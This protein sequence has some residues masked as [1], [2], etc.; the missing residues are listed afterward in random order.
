MKRFLKAAVAA[1]V[2][3]WGSASALAANLSF[4]GNLGG[5]NDVQLFSFSLTSTA[6]VTLRT[7]SYAGGSN[8]AGAAIGA[9]GFDA[10]VAL[11]SGTGGAALLIN[12][13]D[14]G[15]GVA[16]DPGTG[17]AYDALLE[18][19]ALSAGDYTVALTNFANFAN[20]PTLDDGFLDA[21]EAGF[22]GRTSAW[23][24]DILG[25]DAASPIPESG[26]LAL[27]G[28]GLCVAALARRRAVA[29]A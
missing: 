4:T 24:L 26:T 19:F 13:N 1:T 22:N 8:A 25:A 11:F 2:L 18:A 17:F 3:A 29:T 5:D 15:F 16:V 21:G 28:L 9:G 20:G 27:A 23:A 10:V 12:G 6:D 14:D 7:W